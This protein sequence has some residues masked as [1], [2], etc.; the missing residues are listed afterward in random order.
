MIYFLLKSDAENNLVI[1][2]TVNFR[3]KLRQ[4]ALQS[5]SEITKQDIFELCDTLRDELSVANVIVQVNG[6]NKI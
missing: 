6:Y 2:I 1:D 5:K 3:A 4:L